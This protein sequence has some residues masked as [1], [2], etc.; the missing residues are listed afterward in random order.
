[1]QVAAVP[2]QILHALQYLQTVTQSPL[3]PK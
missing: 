2:C 3:S 1:L